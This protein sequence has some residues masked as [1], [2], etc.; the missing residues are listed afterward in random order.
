MIERLKSNPKQLFIVDG[1][2]ALTSAFLLGFVLVKFESVF[3]VPRAALYILA[4]IPLFFIV[5]DFIAYRFST[6]RIPAFLKGIAILNLAY[7]LV[8][9]G[10]AIYHSETVT[11]LGWV[12]IIGEIILVMSLAILELRIAAKMRKS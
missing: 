11:M 1:I 2:G 4:A 10:F 8:S 7:C 5:Y 9:F 3:G 12:Y 6:G